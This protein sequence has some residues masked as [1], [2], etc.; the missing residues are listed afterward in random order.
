MNKENIKNT[1]WNRKFSILIIIVLLIMVVVLFGQ[2]QDYKFTLLYKYQA[3]PDIELINTLTQTQSGLS[4]EV[5]GFVKFDNIADQP[6]NLRQYY[7]I[8]PLNKFD[9]NSRQYFSLE[10]IIKM[11]YLAPRSLGFSEIVE[12]SETGNTITL[13]DESGNKFFIDKSTKKVSTKD[14]TGDST[15]L[16]TSDNDYG[17]FTKGWLKK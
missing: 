11:Q 8:K 4:G 10:E 13:E 3:I 7:I 17:D 5:R 2:K 6:E 16:I 9:E 15:T 14:A 1:I 12:V